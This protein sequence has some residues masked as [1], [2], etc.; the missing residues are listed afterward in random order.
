MADIIQQRRDTAARWASVNPILL[1][2][3]VGY[4]TDNPNQYK[5][6]NG[7][8]R[9]NDLPLRGYTGTIAQE[10]GSDENAVMSQKAVGDILGY[11][12]DNPEYLRAYTDA[13][14]RFLWGIKQ[15]GSIEW[16]KGI[17][18][19]IKNYIAELYRENDEEVERIN[20][21]VIGLLADVEVLTDTYHYISNQEWVCAIVDSDEHILMGIK[22]DGSFYVPNR[23]MYHTISSPE[24]IKAVVDADGEI[25]EGLG[26]DGKKFFPKQELFEKYYD[27]EGRTEI[28]LDASGKVVAFR[29]RDGVRHENKFIAKQLVTKSL[30]LPPDAIAQVDNIMKRIKCGKEFRLPSYGYVDIIE[31]TFYL[32]Y[33]ESYS[34]KDGIY[35]VQIHEDTQENAQEGLTLIKFYVKSTLTDNGDGTYSV[36]SG[37]IPLDFYAASKVTSVGGLH[38]ASETLQEGSVVDTSVRVTK[39]VD[40]PTI[41]AWSVDKKTEHYCIVKIDFGDY[42]NGTFNIGVK[43]QGSSTLYNRKRNFRFTFYKSSTFATK[44]KIK[45]GEMVRTSDFNLKANYVDSSKVKELVM[46]RIFISIWDD[47]DVNNRYPWVKEH[48]PYTGAVGMIKGFPVQVKIGGQFYGINIFGLKK[49]KRNFILDG[50]SDGMIVS[51]CAGKGS[52]TNYQYYKWEDEMNDEMTTSNQSALDSFFEFINS[53]NFNKETVPNR[54]SV[55]D[56]IDYFICLQVFLMRDNTFRNMILHTRED[57]EKFYPFFYDLDLSWFWSDASLDIFDETYAEDMGVWSSIKDLYWDEIINRYHELR[58][59]SLSLSSINMIVDNIIANIPNGDYER[60]SN[61]W[62]YASKQDMNTLMDKLEQRLQYLDN[63]YFV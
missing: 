4:V 47:R 12:E 2:G 1:E 30:V 35:P 13:D 8:S 43:Y 18:T 6:G 63:E 60:E 21:L 56:W 17:P 37:S 40:K 54:M 41:G 14:G 58:G 3:E 36:N 61:K 5:I 44:D 23:D 39:I 31:E 33:N 38:Y 50:D 45:L 10:G 32:T 52:W 42:L 25:L 7:V 53:D 15:D 62:G 28:T 49:D 16:A 59:S 20:Q 34:D 24:W 29:D 48:T 9:W 57:K 11:Y 55:I 19:P 46:N 27:V 26:N 22:S 51:G